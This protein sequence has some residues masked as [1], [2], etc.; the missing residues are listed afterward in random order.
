MKVLR[1]ARNIIN[2]QMRDERLHY[3]YRV[4]I[5]YQDF[6]EKFGRKLS[7]AE[8]FEDRSA[9]RSVLDR[10]SELARRRA[11]HRHVRSVELHGIHNARTKKRRSK[12]INEYLTLRNTLALANSVSLP[13]SALKLQCL[14]T[15]LVSVSLPFFRVACKGFGVAQHS[16]VI[17][18]FRSS[19]DSPKYLSTCD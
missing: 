4:A 17:V 6:L 19:G 3:P 13:Y 10:I 18:I 5:Q 2:R 15:V 7:P 9:A 14:H 8:L 16:N 11:K 1:A 12:R